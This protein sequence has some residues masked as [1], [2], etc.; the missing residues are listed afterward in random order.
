MHTY[1]VVDVS[2]P[3]LRGCIAGTMHTRG[4]DDKSQQ[5]VSIT[6]AIYYAAED[7]ANK[8]SQHNCTMLP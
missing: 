1:S 5:A 8:T 3:V 7:E 2:S 4:A 6:E